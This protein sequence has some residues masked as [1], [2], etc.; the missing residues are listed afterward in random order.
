MGL[1][2]MLGWFIVAL[3]LCSFCI[4]FVLG[5]FLNLAWYLSVLG[6]WGSLALGIGFICIVALFCKRTSK[7][8]K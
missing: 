7:P 3:L 5:F 1:L 8:S 2:R 4:F 6:L